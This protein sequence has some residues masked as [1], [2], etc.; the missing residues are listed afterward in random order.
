[1]D[2]A[3]AR[4]LVTRATIEA[5][6]ADGWLVVDD[7]GEIDVATLSSM[8]RL[9]QSLERGRLGLARRRR[10]P[11]ALTVEQA[12]LWLGVPMQTVHRMVTTGELER[13]EVFLQGPERLRRPP[14]PPPSS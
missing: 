10:L 9:L 5:W 11:P 3:A 4:L 1:M 6:V 12:A 2:E 14:P 7:E 13:V 8:E